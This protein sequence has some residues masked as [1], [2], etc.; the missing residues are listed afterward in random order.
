M[1]FKTNGA[2]VPAFKL[3]QST[4][5]SRDVLKTS[6][7]VLTALAHTGKPELD[8]LMKTSSL[9]MRLLGLLKFRSA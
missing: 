1:L 5:V 7:W 6:M 4:E 9:P 3:V 2:L 8:A